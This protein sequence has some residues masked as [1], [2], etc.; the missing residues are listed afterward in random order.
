MSLMLGFGERDGVIRGA[1]VMGF[2]A[3]GSLIRE[4]EWVGLVIER[5]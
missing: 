2:G 1:S 4:V 3:R 5:V